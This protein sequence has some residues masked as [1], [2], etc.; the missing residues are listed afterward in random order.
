MR[1][2]FLAGG[3][4]AQLLPENPAHQDAAPEVPSWLPPVMD[5]SVL[6][7]ALLL[8]PVLLGLYATIHALWL[9][10]AAGTLQVFTRTCGHTLSTIPVEVIPD[11]CHYLCTV[12]A[13]GHEW[14]VRPLRVGRRHGVPKPLEWLFYLA[15][16][17][18]DRHDPEARIDRMYRP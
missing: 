7:K 3:R 16:L 11:D 18:Q 8:S 1:D 6:E 12:A 2:G 9:R 15:L 13:N 10:N 14:L 17:M 5:S 4:D